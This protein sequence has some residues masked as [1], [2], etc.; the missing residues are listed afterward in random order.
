MRVAPPIQA[1]SG[2]EA[3]PEQQKAFHEKREAAR[4][5]E[6]IFVRK[7]LA[8]LEKSSKPGATGE[9]G[10]GGAGGIYASM[11]VSALSDAVSASGGI[12][13]ADVILQALT[14]GQAPKK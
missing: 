4:A 13:L 5:F 12:G 10:G 2:P 6:A 7:M 3:T 9:A 11:M 8:S 1:P 14:P